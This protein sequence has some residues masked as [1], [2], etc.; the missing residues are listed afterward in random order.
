MSKA[1]LNAPHGGAL[2]DRVVPSAAREAALA[3]A[4]ALPR[5][6]LSD[7]SLCD[8]VCIGTGVYS[9]LHGFMGQADYRSVVGSMRLAGGHT[10]A[11]STGAGMPLDDRLATIVL[12]KGLPVGSQL[13]AS[14]LEWQKIRRLAS[15]SASRSRS[16]KFCDGLR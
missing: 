13:T 9:P 10:K 7:R 2:V 1:A 11:R 8:V 3:A 15:S 12:G 4:A 14:P 5:V 16:G 6:A